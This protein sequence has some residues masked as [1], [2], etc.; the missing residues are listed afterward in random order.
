[1][2]ERTQQLQYIPI[3]EEQKKYTSVHT[4]GITE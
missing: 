3:T 1:M 4:G 2:E